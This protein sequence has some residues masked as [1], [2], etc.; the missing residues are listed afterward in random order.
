[1]TATSL[2]EPEAL[3]AR[4]P[5]PA[6]ATVCGYVAAIAGVEAVAAFGSPVTAAALHGVLLAILLGHYLWTGE[7]AIAALS[8]VPLL[9]ISGLAL[10]SSHL[11]ATYVLAGLPV[12]AGIILAAHALDVPGVLAVWQIRRRS[13]WHVALATLVIA[14]VAAALLSVPPVSSGG[15]AAELLAAAAAVFV[16]AGVLEELLFRGVIQATLEPVARG[17][18]VVLA[19][20]LF[21]ATYLGSGSPAYAVFMALFGLAC[22]WWVRRTGSVAGAAVAHG[23]LAAGVLVVWP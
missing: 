4:R 6:A 11:T 5:W 17:W 12:L 3:A 23:L 18:S 15:S 9:R 21:A 8:L 13:Q 22:G 19:D 1:M 7:R 16:F 14:R 20:T 2:P 10:A